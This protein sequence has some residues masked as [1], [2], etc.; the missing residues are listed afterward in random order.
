MDSFRMRFVIGK[1]TNAELEY[2]RSGL[3]VI[4]KMLLIPEDY[5]LFHYEEGD[6]IEAETEDG[7]RIW[8]TIKSMEVV[9]DP[10]RV[11]IIFTLAPQEPKE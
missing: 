10:E 6:D 7:N 9:E 3:P 4:S 5:R 2:L 1:L 11:I 8:T